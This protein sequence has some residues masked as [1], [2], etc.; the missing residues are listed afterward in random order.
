MHQINKLTK[1]YFLKKGTGCFQMAKVGK[2]RQIKKWIMETTP[3][4]RASDSI[5]ST[6]KKKKGKIYF[7][8]LNYNNFFIKLLSFYFISLSPYTFIYAPIESQ[9]E[10]SLKICKN[11]RGSMYCVNNSIRAQCIHK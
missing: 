10:N 7:K 9:F 6:T 4:S 3:M 2:G 11:F 5:S 8:P 1:N